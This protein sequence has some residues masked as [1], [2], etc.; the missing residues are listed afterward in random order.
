M[1]LP[2]VIAVLLMPNE[3]IIAGIKT[4][5]QHP[6]D[7]N[8]HNDMVI[9]YQLGSDR[10][11]WSTVS[12]IELCEVSTCRVKQITILIITFIRTKLQSH[13]KS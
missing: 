6:F 3:L 5:T 4:A 7:R 9:F 13:T 11:R 10:H 2:I 1:P 12:T 8:E